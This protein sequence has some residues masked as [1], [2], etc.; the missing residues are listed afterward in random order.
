LDSGGFTE[1]STYGEW[2]TSPEEYILRART[3]A[4]EIGNLD[5]AAPQDWMCE[6][7]ILAKTGKTIA[8]H[9][10]LTIENFLALRSAEPWFIPV[11]QGFYRNDY[12]RHWEAYERAGVHL[13][14]EPLVGLGTV[15]RRQD[16]A[17]AMTIVMTLQPLRLHGFGI[18][19]GGL[20]RYGHLLASSDSMA[21]SVGGR[22]RKPD[23]HIGCTRKACANCSEYA[24]VWRDQVLA[25]VESNEQRMRQLVAESV[26]G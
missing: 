13:E 8:E 22:Y 5:F 10:R 19:V 17:A 23:L 24:L 12:L 2:R 4:R 25:G 15:C 21:W 7:W 9:Q 16:T 14:D 3:Y 6:P 26:F 1:L 20:Y 18:K 11:L